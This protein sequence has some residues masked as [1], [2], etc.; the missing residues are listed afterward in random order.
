M[1]FRF[2]SRTGLGSPD[3]TCTAPFM[4]DLDYWQL[5]CSTLAFSVRTSRCSPKDAV[6]SCTSEPRELC[7]QHL[8]L[9]SE[10]RSW[11]TATRFKNSAVYVGSDSRPKARHS[12]C[13]FCDCSLFAFSLVHNLAIDNLEAQ[14]REKFLVSASLFSSADCHASCLHPCQILGPNPYCHKFLVF[15]PH[16]RFTF[17][18]SR[19]FSNDQRVRTSDS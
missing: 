14:V 16:V 12:S 9:I 13:T 8:V 5:F 4:F 3:S 2:S 7:P 6:A 17:H 19:N 10:S 18:W 15:C 11:T 1:P